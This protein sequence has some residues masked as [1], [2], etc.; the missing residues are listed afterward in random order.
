M[1]AVSDEV[2][3]NTGLNLTGISLRFIPA[4]YPQR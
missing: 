4:G 2:P 1:Q 3:H